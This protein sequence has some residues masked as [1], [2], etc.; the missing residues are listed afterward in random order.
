MHLLITGF[1]PFPGAPFNPTQRIARRLG[2][3]KRPLLADVKRTVELLPTT[4][5]AIAALPRMILTMKPDAVLMFGLAGRRR[6]VT[7][8]LRGMNM[9][10][11]LHPD[12]AG[13]R[14][15]RQALSV[16]EP[17]SRQASIP[18]P[19][20]AARMRQARVMAKPSNS[21]GDYLCNAG[22][23]TAL[24]VGVP[25]LFVHVPRARRIGRPVKPARWPRQ[26]RAAIDRACEI[27]LMEMVRRFR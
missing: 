1:G 27:A 4:H 18:V 11:V 3:L 25:A 16:G 7:P 5:E 21:A 12:A 20:L 2:A 8:E 14:P 15:A 23:Y 19:A 26:N 22:I 10:S 6:H 24:G 13:K 9:V 17:F